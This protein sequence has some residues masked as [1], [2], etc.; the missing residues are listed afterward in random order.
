MGSG[1]IASLPRLKGNHDWCHERMRKIHLLVPE[2]DA[3]ASRFFCC[4]SFGHC[5]CQ[6]R[7]ERDCQIPTPA[8]N[9]ANLKKSDGQGAASP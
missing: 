3:L 7:V 6:V 2:P 8:S 1:A 9:A 4:T 5:V